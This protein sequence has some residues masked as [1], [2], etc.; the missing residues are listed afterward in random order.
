MG[1]AGSPNIFQAKMLDLMMSLEYVTM[2]LDNLLVISSGSFADHLNKLRVVL[3]RLSD[4]GLKVNADKCNFCTDEIEYLG[5]VLTSDGIKPQKN[6]VQAI[7]TLL[8]PK[9]VKQ[10]RA[11]LRMVQYY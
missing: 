8:L 11:F 3:Q 2:Y 6:K 10:L 9:G 4:A 1:I 5:Y 7:L